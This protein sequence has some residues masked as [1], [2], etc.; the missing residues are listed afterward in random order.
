MELELCAALVDFANPLA[1]DNL[2][3]RCVLNFCFST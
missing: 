3:P 1:Q 2:L